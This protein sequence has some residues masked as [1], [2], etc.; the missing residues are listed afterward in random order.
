MHWSD[1]FTAGQL[2]EVFSKPTKSWSKEYRDIVNE[3]LA[4]ELLDAFIENADDEQYRERIKEIVESTTYGYQDDEGNEM[5]D[6]E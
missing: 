5:L 4:Y 3:I 2:R 1:H 6:F